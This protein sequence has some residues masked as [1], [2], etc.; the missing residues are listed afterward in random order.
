MPTATVNGVKL[1]YEVTGEGFPL[2]LSHEF[3]GS[4]KSWEPQVRFFSRRYQV[5]TYNHRGF[6]PSEVPEGEAAYSQEL[7]VEDLRQLLGHLGIRQAFVGGLS[8]G[9]SVALNFG[10]AHPEMAKAL[11]VAAT[12]T[13]STDRERFE[14]EL[15]QVARQFETQ[16]VK[17]VAESLTKSPTRI[18][19]L[20]KDPKGWQEF[21]DDFITHSATGSA[22][23]LRGIVLKRP[24]IFALQSKLQQLKVP[25][26][27][28]TGDEDD[29][30]IE[31]AIFMKRNIP[32]SGLVV[33]PQSGH[34]INLEEPDLFNR[35]VLDFLTSV[36][37][38]KWAVRQPQLV[39]ASP[40][41]AAKK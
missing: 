16:G 21:Y 29:A 28:L 23:T 17:A 31:P 19:L 24:T 20:R 22:H 2:V 30:C 41:F 18:Q 35:V 9:G 3:G 10:I 15:E 4:F 14:A 5:I 36:E 40:F 33:F 11:I 32:S 27:I 7:L 8:M 34:A 25:T 12:G 39:G 13:G 38:G 37:A 1:Y 6:P 26:L